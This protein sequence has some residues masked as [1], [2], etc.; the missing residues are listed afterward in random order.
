MQVKGLRRA[1]VMQECAWHL[2]GNHKEA[3]RLEQ[4]EQEEANGRRSSR[5]DANLYLDYVETNSRQCG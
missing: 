5:E 1:N 3:T 2:L 4:S